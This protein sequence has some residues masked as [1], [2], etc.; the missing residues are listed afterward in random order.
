MKLANTFEELF[1]AFDMLDNC[2]TYQ[3]IM[4]KRNR[5]NAAIEILV[6]IYN[7]YYDIVNNPI[8]EQDVD[9]NIIIEFKDDDGEKEI[10][11]KIAKNGFFVIEYLTDNELRNTISSNLANFDE[12][13]GF[14]AECMI[15][16]LD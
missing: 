7:N 11:A 12:V 2:V 14:L 5:L 8:I 15:E 1:D 16:Y 9:G 13:E 4:E 6:E 3:D 10:K